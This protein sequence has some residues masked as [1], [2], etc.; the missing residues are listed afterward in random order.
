MTV[1]TERDKRFRR[2]SRPARPRRATVRWFR[3]LGHLCLAGGLFV[4]GYQVVEALLLGPVF[5]VGDIVVEGND[6]LSEGELLALLSDLKGQR[7]LE[8]D[9][10]VYRHRLAASPWLVGGTLRRILPSTIEV[11]VEER[12]PVALAR[13]SDLL[14]LI[15]KSGEVIAQYGPRFEEFDL[16]IIDGLTISRGSA[17]VVEPMRMAL[18]MKLLDQLS[19]HPEELRAISQVDVED[20]YNAVVLLNDDSALLH[21]GGDRFVERLRFYAELASTLRS[22]VRDIDYVDLRFE[23]RVY[24]RPMT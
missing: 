23:K 22:S 3:M 14:Y 10:E 16:P 15:D 17:A 1:I 13:F 6:K 4:G 2:S 7:I 8:V 24:V 21:L 5:R 19:L 18:A 11:S 12:I 9:L 20:P